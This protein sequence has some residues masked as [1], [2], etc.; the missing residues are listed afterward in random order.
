ML[1]DER[2][3]FLDALEDIP[4]AYVATNLRGVI[5]DA[6]AQAAS[7]LG[8]SRLV[9][10]LLVGYVA[11]RDVDCFR[12]ALHDLAKQERR[13]SVMNLR[14]RERGGPPFS[15]LLSVRVVYGLGRL[16]VALRWLIYGDAPTNE[17]ARGIPALVTP[18]QE[19]PP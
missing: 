15:A 14:M 13:E 4:G 1:A 16:P 17:D 8:D 11:R 12:Q 18:L 9:D 6:N 7:L 3:K 2:A 10:K 5:L 19:S